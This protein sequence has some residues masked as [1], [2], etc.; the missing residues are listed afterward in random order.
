MQ[1]FALFPTEGPAHDPASR[2]RF[3]S[4]VGASRMQELA[5]LAKDPSWC[6]D[7]YTRAR[8]EWV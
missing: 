8:R 4:K 7:V 1:S 2:A 6:E 5:K 3:E